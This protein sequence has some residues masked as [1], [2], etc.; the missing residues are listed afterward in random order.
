[1]TSTF[2]LSSIVWLDGTS[3]CRLVFSVILQGMISAVC[4][5]SPQHFTHIAQNFHYY[6]FSDNK[7]NIMCGNHIFVVHPRI[8]I[9]R[10]NRSFPVCL[11]LLLHETYV[12][13][14][15]LVS[16]PTREFR[17]LPC[18]YWWQEFKR[19]IKLSNLFKPAFM[20]MR[21]MISNLLGD[22]SRSTWRYHKL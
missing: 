16:L 22:S 7:L 19:N 10:R 5:L 1:M 14:V 2:P 18:C 9:I 11:A 17:R 15:A 12:L 20:K 4:D 6:S 3:R 8:R 13:Y 21:Q